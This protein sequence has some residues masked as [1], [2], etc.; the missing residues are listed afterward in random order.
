MKACLEA[1]GSDL[2]HVLECNVLCVSAS[3]FPTF[4]AIYAG[5]FPRGPTGSDLLMRLRMVGTL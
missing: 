4:N 3:R 2:D 1:A 5:Y